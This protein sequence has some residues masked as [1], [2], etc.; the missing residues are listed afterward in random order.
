MTKKLAG[1]SILAL[2]ALAVA[3]ASPSPAAAQSVLEPAPP[4]PDAG[5]PDDEMIMLAEEPGSNAPDLRVLVAAPRAAVIG[6]ASAVLLAMR[7]GRVLHVE[8]GESIRFVSGVR[9]AVWYAGAGVVGS[10]LSLSGGPAG[11]P[12]GPL[13]DSGIALPGQA[14]RIDRGR[15]FVDVTYGTA[16]EYAVDAAVR[17][18]VSPR[19]GR[20]RRA[21]QHALYRVQVFTPGTLATISGFV[22]RVS[23]GTAIGGY[24]VVALNSSTLAPVEGAVTRPD[25]SYTIRRLPPGDYLVAAPSRRGFEGELWNDVTDPAS[26]SAIH[27]AA[28]QAQSGIDFQLSMP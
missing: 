14:P 28:G 12:P 23:D 18:G 16:G 20:A 8:E 17:A 27:L 13:G 26:A 7:P 15:A 5:F 22:G 1:I 11:A 4:P 2:V 6:K 25:G 10:G 21:S 19:R 24:P 3:F 9:E